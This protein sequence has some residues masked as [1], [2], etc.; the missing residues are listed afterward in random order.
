MLNAAQAGQDSLNLAGN[1]A[2]CAFI[3]VLA[4]ESGYSIVGNG[5]DSA[6]VQHSD[7]YRRVGVLADNLVVGPS[8]DFLTPST[9]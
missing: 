5:S 4:L 9:S 3:L 7:A 6:A 1:N 2:D 8:I